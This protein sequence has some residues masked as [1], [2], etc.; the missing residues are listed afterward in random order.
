MT[1]KKTGN[2]R[3]SKRGMPTL[4]VPSRNGFVDIGSISVSPIEDVQEWTPTF[5]GTGGLIFTPDQALEARYARIGPFLWFNM[6]ARGTTSGSSGQQIRFT[7]PYQV[8]RLGGLGGANNSPITPLV[9]NGSSGGFAEASASIGNTPT[10]EISVTNEG[11]TLW[12]LGSAR[13]VACQGMMELA[14]PSDYYQPKQEIRKLLQDSFFDIPGAVA[15]N[16]EK[17]LLEYYNREVIGLAGKGDF[18]GGSVIVERVN[19][20]V[21]VTIKET[22]TFASSDNPVSGAGALPEWARPGLDVENVAFANAD[23]DLWVCESRA[24]GSFE[25]EF[26]DYAGLGVN[27]TNISVGLSVSYSVE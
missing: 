25:M 23:A 16:G 22:I 9:R 26:R 11:T 8:G 13:I 20:Q 15:A 5:S 7:L 6:Y 24:D 21:T 4:A 1:V 12:T 17:G 3:A 2:F 27:R 19:K 10:N 18:T 14:D